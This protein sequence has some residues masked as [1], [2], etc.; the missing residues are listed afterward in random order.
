M[1]EPPTLAVTI[2]AHPKR[3][4]W[5]PDLI[6]RLSFG[7][8]STDLLSVTWDQHNDRWDT[9]SRA[10]RWAKQTG[11]SHVLVV[12]DDAIIPPTLVKGMFP[13]IEAAPDEAV[14]L[15][16]GK[17]KPRMGMVTR[18]V[19]ATQDFTLLHGPGPW[20]A[21][22]L[23]LPTHDLERV[24]VFGSRYTQSANIDHRIE[25]GLRRIGKSCL[26]TVPS[27]VD[28]RPEDENPSLVPGRVAPG[29]VAHRYV[30]EDVDLA[31]VQWSRGHAITRPPRKPRKVQTR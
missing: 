2:T 25:H 26:Y 19:N 18:A 4:R 28:H 7:V 5:V 15:Y 9:A 23:L 20:W 13:L 21:L 14:C 31:N 29:R 30:G 22:G 16:V 24:V 17:V 3:E 6:H 10:L 1:T 11:A 12:Q 8:E 27:L